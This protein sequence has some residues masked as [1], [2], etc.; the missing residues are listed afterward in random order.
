MRAPASC[1]SPLYLT[2][3]L[4][5]PELFSQTV[6]IHAELSG[7]PFELLRPSRKSLGDAS[8]NAPLDLLDVFG[9]PGGTPFHW[10]KEGK[11]GLGD[12]IQIRF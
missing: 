6:L 4:K 12:L 8:A 1:R 3:P 11:N 9:K 10:C 5:V 7:D 2:N